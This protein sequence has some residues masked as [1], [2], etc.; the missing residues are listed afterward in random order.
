M[1]TESGY[2]SDAEAESIEKAV[3]EHFER[4]LALESKVEFAEHIELTIG[5]R[6]PPA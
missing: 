1:T 3:R 4:M 2:L 6:E 5:F